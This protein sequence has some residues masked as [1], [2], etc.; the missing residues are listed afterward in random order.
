MV[1]V[2]PA[3]LV[4]KC[5]FENKNLDPP[6]KYSFNEQMNYIRGNQKV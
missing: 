1:Y 4:L 3:S 5:G 6:C 2:D